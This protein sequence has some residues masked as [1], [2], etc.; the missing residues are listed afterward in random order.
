MR[1]KLVDVKKYDS[2]MALYEWFVVEWGKPLSN[3]L[4]RQA[5]MAAWAFSIDKGMV[6]L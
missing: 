5:Y 2:P 4:K 6:K 1:E 3:E